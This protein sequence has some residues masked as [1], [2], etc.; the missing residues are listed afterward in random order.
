MFKTKFPTF[1]VITIFMLKLIASSEKQLGKR[2]T[3]LEIFL[4]FSKSLLEVELPWENF[5]MG[6]N[7]K[8]LSTFQ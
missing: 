2:I 1:F 3:A 4:Y 6:I 5:K 7:K 8:I